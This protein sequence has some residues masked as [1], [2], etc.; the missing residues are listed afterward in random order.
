M[1]RNNELLQNVFINAKPKTAADIII[2]GITTAFSLNP[3]IIDYNK[4]ILN[5]A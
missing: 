1:K 4:V 5:Y 2:N 3:M